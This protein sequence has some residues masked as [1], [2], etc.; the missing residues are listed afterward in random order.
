VSNMSAS[1]SIARM[2][3]PGWDSAGGRQRMDP[4]N[5]PPVGKAMSTKSVG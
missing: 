5:D 2:S 3:A 4:R 1:V